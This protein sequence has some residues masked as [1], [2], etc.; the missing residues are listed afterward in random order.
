MKSTAK[1]LLIWGAWITIPIAIS[2]YISL[3]ST[4][5]TRSFSTKLVKE[6]LTIGLPYA[7]F[8]FF[9]VLALI[10]KQ[11]RKIPYLIGLDIICIFLMVWSISRFYEGPKLAISSLII[12]V[13]FIVAKTILILQ[14]N[15][16]VKFQ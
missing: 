11:F 6:I 10:T 13:S 7:I 14:K 8:T 1:K 5:D 16:Q 2:I 4:Y 3:Q 15:K 12:I 9:Y